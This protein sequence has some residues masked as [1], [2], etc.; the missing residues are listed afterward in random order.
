MVLKSN[1][2]VSLCGL[3][4]TYAHHTQVCL[5]LHFATVYGLRTDLGGCKVSK[6]FGG[7]CSQ[8]PIIASAF[9]AEVRTNVLVCPCCALASA[10]SWLC[11]CTR[12]TIISKGSFREGEPKNIIFEL[13]QKAYKPLQGCKL[14]VFMYRHIGPT[15]EISVSS[16]LLSPLYCVRTKAIFMS[17]GS[18]REG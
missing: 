1:G 7:G 11:H 14:L 8:T 6:F 12:A 15:M 3:R 18:F 10:M 17:K 9:R 4:V 2:A 16:G 13:V 5:D